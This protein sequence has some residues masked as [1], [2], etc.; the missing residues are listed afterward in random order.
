M[1]LISVTGFIAASL[2]S[3]V[4]VLPRGHHAAMVSPAAVGLYEVV[5]NDIQRLDAV[6]YPRLRIP[7]V[8]TQKKLISSKPGMSILKRTLLGPRQ[9]CDAGYGYCDG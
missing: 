3:A 2:C 5:V 1:Y 9:T 4:Q 7:T 8:P 6:T